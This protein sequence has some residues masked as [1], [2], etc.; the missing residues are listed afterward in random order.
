MSMSQLNKTTHLNKTA[1]QIAKRLTS[2][3]IHSTP[4]ATKRKGAPKGRSATL[5]NAS[6][7]KPI[8]DGLPDDD[9]DEFDTGSPRSKAYERITTQFDAE[10]K[11]LQEKLM[12]DEEENK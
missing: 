9:E 3:N 2:G 8:L 6:Q 5:W 11:Q 7:P 4:Q 1:A 10:F 12:A